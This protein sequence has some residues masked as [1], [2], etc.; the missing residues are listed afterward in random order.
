MSQKKKGTPIIAV[1]I[2]IGNNAPG[3]ITLD[4]TDAVESKNA[5]IKNDNGKKKR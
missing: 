1:T 5:P 2:P 3:T 4:S